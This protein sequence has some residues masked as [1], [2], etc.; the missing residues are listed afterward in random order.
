MAE[1]TEKKFIN[2]PEY[3]RIYKSG[4]FGR[5]MPDG[6]IVFT[7]RQDDLIKLRGQRIELG[8]INS[9]LINHYY[10]ENCA[11][12]VGGGEEGRQQLLTFW[13]PTKAGAEKVSHTEDEASFVQDLFDHLSR[14][15]PSYMVPSFII[16]VDWLPITGAGKTDNSTLLTKFQQMDAQTLDRY[17]RGS[18]TGQ[19][20]EEFSKIED[21]V[22]EIVAKITEAPRADI[23]RHSS[24]YRLGLDSILA[25]S[26]SRQLKLAGFGQVDVSTVMKNDSVARLAKEIQ[27]GSSDTILPTVSSAF[28]GLFSPGFVSQVEEWATAGGMKV[29][30]ILPSTSLQESMLSGTVSGDQAS[31]YNHITFEIIEDIQKLKAAWKGMVA[32]HD[33]LRTVFRSTDDARFTFAQVVLESVD[34][35][36]KAVQCLDSDLTSIIDGS[37][38]NILSDGSDAYK[39]PYSFV[40]YYCTDTRKIYLHLSIHHALYDG[41]AMEQLLEDVESHLLGIQLSPAV[42]FDLYLQRMVETDSDSTDKFWSRYLSEFSPSPLF[43]SRNGSQVSKEFSVAVGQFQLPLADITA[44]CKSS[45]VSLLNVL[46]AAWVK[47]L[48][49]L[50]GLS[51]ICFGDV[52]N[53]RNSPIDGIERVV[54]PCF[55]T[56]PVRT[57]INQNTMNIDLMTSLQAH[58]ADTFQYQLSSLRRLQSRFGQSGNRLFD[59]LVLLQSSPRPLNDRVW[60]QIGDTGN[61]D[62]P[63]VCEIIPSRESDKLELYFH[64]DQ[65]MLSPEQASAMMESY[66]KI[67][68]HTLNFPS[69]RAMDFSVLSNDFAPLFESFA[70]RKTDTKA[71]G[72]DSPDADEWKPEALKARSLLSTLSNINEQSI[73]LRTTIFQLGLDSINAIQVAGHF[74]KMGYEITA[75]DILEVCFFHVLILPY[76]WLT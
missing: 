70:H 53:C 22:A 68:D 28:E 60:N 56:L 15:L 1:L 17:S 18:Q 62:F 31:Y 8:E 41:E 40:E 55:N 51:D 69:S 57:K 4:D 36:W 46:Q 54:G 45:S 23:G 10:V 6:S 65:S 11:T 2:H 42:P 3:G 58:K 29:Q 73:E 71:D 72:C 47:L 27:Q 38:S 75:T 35:P 43:P 12:M 76:L 67:I 49:Y 30:K 34:M 20:S 24:F 13:V 50:S 37:H 21:D 48:S 39:M 25:I 64:F 16:P 9:V 26:L 7:G 44:A 61:M 66:S 52:M 14:N 63:L 33:I 74:K 19:D 59:T 32:R 5:M